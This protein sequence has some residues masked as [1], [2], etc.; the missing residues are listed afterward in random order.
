MK[1]RRLIK[2]T[3]M[4]LLWQTVL[5]KHVISICPMHTQVLLP[6]HVH[7]STIAED[8]KVA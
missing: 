4:S 8:T 3:R 2:K 1:S 7:R 6:V 5:I